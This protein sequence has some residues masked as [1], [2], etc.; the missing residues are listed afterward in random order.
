M[1]IASG[2]FPFHARP[3]ML[4]AALLT[5]R[6]NRAAGPKLHFL[7]VARD[8]YAMLVTHEAFHFEVELAATH[9]ELIHGRSLYREASLTR[10]ELPN[11]WT[12]GPL[13]EL[14]ATWF[15]LQARTRHQR[16]VREWTRV[17]RH[18]APPGY[19]DFNR[20]REARIRTVMIDQLTSD[21]VG[22]PTQWL[23]EPLDDQDLTE[24]NVRLDDAKFAYV[25]D[26]FVPKERVAPISH[27]TFAKWF[28]RHVQPLGGEIRTRGGDHPKKVY[29]PGRGDYS[30]ST[31]KRNGQTIIPHHEMRGLARHIGYPSSGA[32]RMAIVHDDPPRE[33]QA[34][35]RV[36]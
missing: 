11:P 22:A 21:I 7:T 25:F 27:R 10:F 24:V 15:E 16:P 20:A 14:L 13:E 3:F 18:D 30:L 26:S 5:G 4:S 19:R 12:S 17:T 33:L 29:V 1:V 9:F 23:I 34:R 2:E 35:L 28:A 32:L 31:S 36:R 8:L 6:V